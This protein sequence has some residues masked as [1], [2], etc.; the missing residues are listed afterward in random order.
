[1]WGGAGTSVTGERQERSVKVVSQH[2]GCLGQQNQRCL[3]NMESTPPPPA[4]NV[5][6]RP[7]EGQGLVQNPP[8]HS[9]PLHSRGAGLCP[10]M[11]P[12]V[13][14]PQQPGSGRPLPGPVGAAPGWGGVWGLLW[15]LPQHL[16][17]PP[18]PPSFPGIRGTRVRAFAGGGPGNRGCLTCP[19]QWPQSAPGQCRAATNYPGT[20]R[21]GLS[22]GG[23][24]ALPSLITL[25]PSQVAPAGGSRDQEYR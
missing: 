4:Q 6:V 15:E 16:A 25:P 8:V 5:K 11:Y 10:S 17:I 24:D 1:M 9:L 2:P 13:L 21:C 22:T 23:R 20:W 18:E 3:E 7:R 19:H 12:L 14:P